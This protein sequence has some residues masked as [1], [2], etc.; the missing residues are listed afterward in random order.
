MIFNNKR[1]AIRQPLSREQDRKASFGFIPALLG[2]DPT[3]IP[4][5]S[6]AQDVLS[7]LALGYLPRR[8][9]QEGSGSS[10]LGSCCE[11]HGAS[12]WCQECEHLILLF[13]HFSASF[14]FLRLLDSDE[15]LHHETDLDSLPLLWFSNI[16]V[17]LPQP[18]T[19]FLLSPFSASLFCNL[20]F[21]KQQQ[22]VKTLSPSVTKSCSLKPSYACRA[23]KTRPT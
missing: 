13:F 1:S 18:C 12:Y 9:L 19:F 16:S 14:R 6:H 8:A 7:V 10:G 3:A 2:I 20:D 15:L 17:S 21:D 22:H 11:E 4:R 23:I 5:E